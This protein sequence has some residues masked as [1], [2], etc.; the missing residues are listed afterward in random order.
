MS[1]DLHPE[2]SSCA[3]TVPTTAPVQVLTLDG[4]ID[5]RPSY[6]PRSFSAYKLN[7]ITDFEVIWTSNLLDHLRLID[8]GDTGI[9][10]FIFHHTM[11][12]DL[13]LSLPK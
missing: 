4:N 2:C 12:L 5:G 9:K 6:F 3:S 1:C 7:Y 8:E 13:H 11:L 10:V